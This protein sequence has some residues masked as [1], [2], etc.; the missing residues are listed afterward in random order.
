MFSGPCQRLNYRL[1]WFRTYNK[2][3]ICDSLFIDA[4]L[5]VIRLHTIIMDMDVIA[6]LGFLIIDLNYLFFS[7]DE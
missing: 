4:T 7:E 6:I 1:V 3:F 2:I 5:E